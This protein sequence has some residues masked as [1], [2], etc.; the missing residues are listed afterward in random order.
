MARFRFSEALRIGTLLILIVGVGLLATGCGSKK[1]TTT[2]KVNVRI[3]RINQDKDPIKDMIK[4]FQKAYPQTVITYK[5]KSAQDYELESL[6][7]L[8]ARQG[9]DIWSIPDDWLWDHKDRVSPLPDTFFQNEKKQGPT[10][11]AAIKELYPAGIVQQLTDTDGKVYGLPSTVDVLRLYVNT[12]MLATAVTEYRK[13]QGNN[14]NEAAYAEVRQLF[15]N[16]PATWNDVLKQTKYL[17][18]RNGTQVT[19]SAIALGTADNIP[20]SADI[21][22]LLMLQNGAKIVS[23]DRRNA[24]FHIPDTTPSGGQV[25]PG[26][27][28]LEFYTSFSNPNKENYTWSPSMPQAL[29][30]FGQGKVAMVVAFADFGKLLKIK[31]PKFNFTVTTVPQITIEPLQTPVNLVRFSVETVTKTAD[32]Q[33]ISFAFL[34]KYTDRPIVAAYAKQQGLTSPFLKDVKDKKEFPYYQIMTGTAVYKR[35]RTL[36]DAAF[37][38]MIID[39]SQNGVAADKALDA[40]AEEVNVLLKDAREDED[41]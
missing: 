23:T 15:K 26:Q 17:T 36:F 28:A 5:K 35:N 31:Y 27:N 1:V 30:A 18:Q 24:L 37:R 10:P 29:D 9:P 38:Q 22:Q 4:E 13:A 19:R 2:K 11:E 21:L 25:R 40:G 3:W 14:L 32:S 39:A 12:D 16:P 6:K 33:G 34:K 41:Q 7:S 8:A 20:N